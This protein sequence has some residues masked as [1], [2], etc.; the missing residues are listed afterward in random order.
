V[1]SDRRHKTVT[2]FAP[3]RACVLEYDDAEAERAALPDL[4]EDQ[5]TVR[6]R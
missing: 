5:I 1:G 6:A 4:L 2:E 3:W